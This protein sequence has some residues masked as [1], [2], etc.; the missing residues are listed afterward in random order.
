MELRRTE[1]LEWLRG[2]PRSG[3]QPY[4]QAGLPTLGNIV[5]PDVVQLRL[6]EAETNSEVQKVW[7]LIQT[8]PRRLDLL[9]GPTV[10]E[11]KVTLPIGTRLRTGFAPAATAGQD[12]SSAGRQEC[13]WNDGP[14]AVCP[15][16]WRLTL[17]N[18]GTFESRL[19]WTV[20]TPAGD[21]DVI[22]PVQSW[23]VS[24]KTL[25]AEGLVTQ[26]LKLDGE[27][28]DALLSEAVNG[29]VI[30]LHRSGSQLM[31]WDALPPVVRDEAGM[32]LPQ[33][34]EVYD[35]VAKTWDVWLAPGRLEPG[36]AR[37]FTLCYGDTSPLINPLNSPRLP[38]SLPGQVGVATLG[39]GQGLNQS[40][41]PEKGTDGW[42]ASLWLRWKGGAK[43]LLQA[44]GSDPLTWEALADGSLRLQYR[45]RT[46]TT[47]P[48]LDSR[49]PMLV[50]VDWTARDGM[51]RFWVNGLK[52][53]E[54][55][56]TAE[57]QGTFP[58]LEGT[59]GC[60]GDWCDELRWE[61]P[62]SAASW[63]LRWE[64]ER[65]HGQLWEPWNAPASFRPTVLRNAPAGVMA[66]QAGVRPWIDRDASI[67]ALP[68]AWK[69]AAWLTGEGWR[70]DAD[71]SQ[72]R[73]VTLPGSR[74]CAVDYNAR[75]GNWIATG[76]L[77]TPSGDLSVSCRTLGMD[78]EA[79]LVT[80]GGKSA[81][82]LVLPPEPAV[83]TGPGI[84]SLT[85]FP[86]GDGTWRTTV[87]PAV[88]KGDSLV[89]GVPGAGNTVHY[90]VGTGKL[91][92]LIPVGSAVPVGCALVQTVAGRDAAG[93]TVSWELHA[94][95]SGSVDLPKTQTE[96]LVLQEPPTW[97]DASPLG[98]TLRSVTA[99]QS[100]VLPD[101]T[102]ADGFTTASPVAVPRSCG[103]WTAQANYASPV[104]L[105][106]W[107]PFVAPVPRSTDWTLLGV[108]EAGGLTWGHW[109]RNW[110]GGT[111][112]EDLALWLQGACAR[113][114]LAAEEQAVVAPDWTLG[115]VRL[116]GLGGTGSL[117]GGRYRIDGLD[118]EFAA[119]HVLESP[120]YRLRLEGG[121]G[122]AEHLVG[123]SL[124]IGPDREVRLADSASGQ[125]SVI[126][127]RS[128][129]P[130][131]ALRAE[132]LDADSVTVD[133]TSLL[134]KGRVRV[135]VRKNHGAR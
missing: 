31:R 58:R 59:W 2:T 122:R 3:M 98:A 17:S 55:A 35:A 23:T 63:A 118:L 62:Q 91:K 36:R 108:Q 78:G 41:V 52:V 88:L 38:G 7:H 46:W 129:L 21:Q 126:S 44:N 22:E 111:W 54:Q 102:V 110:N 20:H 96:V 32:V 80:G 93:N 74:L 10:L 43:S 40:L 12:G 29:S 53:A 64:G 85:T 120:Q 19:V 47:H 90:A 87:I 6:R 106:L 131:V 68:E 135:M 5:Q 83:T 73:I 130:L 132:R 49:E 60:A 95:P 61:A 14:W 30:H 105:H 134:A 57:D 11:R 101:G 123:Q 116:R 113:Y 42:G 18:Q 65:T 82:W 69:G 92:V 103:D 127:V 15:E 79:T 51:V 125:N 100:V 94:C 86:D 76:T 133:V 119:A 4:W 37:N 99:G 104:R 48:V 117:K 25:E 24:A 84:E 77:S 115:A 114:V 107:S 67:Q 66:A 109:S 97:A 39:A 13:R 45:K 16:T 81:A 72:E 34:T 75:T 124:G 121:A 28:L 70:R 8:P 26:P 71:S 112:R 27:R 89:Q 33:Q 128:R 9:G 50:G 1:R 56:W